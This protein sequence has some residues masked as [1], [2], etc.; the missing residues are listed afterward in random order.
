M[1]IFFTTTTKK[2]YF[3]ALEEYRNY[4]KVSDDPE[5]RDRCIVR[6]R[7]FE[8]EEAMKRG[9]QILFYNFYDKCVIKSDA[10]SFDNISL[11]F[12][13]GDLRGTTQIILYCLEHN[14]P[15]I[16]NRY[17]RKIID[18]WPIFAVGISRRVQVI[19]GAAITYEYIKEFYKDR[20]F[21]KT[22]HKHMSAIFPDDPYVLEYIMGG[23]EAI[24]SE[25][26]DIKKDEEGTLEYR[27]YVINNKLNS[28]SRYSDYK[29]IPVPRKAIEYAKKVID[30]NKNVFVPHYILDICE[31]TDGYYDIVEFNCLESSGRY[32][33]NS[34]KR[35]FDAVDKIK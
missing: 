7:W 11:A 25:V 22:L 24:L 30:M 4:E 28:I 8:M 33:D 1:R 35:M 6:E 16:N 27:C 20:A 23:H 2:D 5:N 29:K 21:V 19:N 3:D 10:I 32:I 15:I 12:I 13:R 31:L 14:I 26:M 9:Y 18:Y 34:V 17:E